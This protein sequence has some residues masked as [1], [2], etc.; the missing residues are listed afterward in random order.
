MAKRIQQV[1]ELIKRELNQLF[2][3]EVGFSRDTLVTITK[4]DTSPNLIQANVYISVLPE[5]KAD[6]IIGF[7]KRN[8]YD[9]QQ[10]LNKR[11]VMRPIPKVVFLR[12][13][14]TIEA[15][16]IE[17]LLEKINKEEVEKKEKN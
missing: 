16:R 10:K 14:K 13:E 8:I 2:L 3:R 7:L 1:N 12:E 11:L 6:A 17:E 15:G 9:L 4:V 5:K